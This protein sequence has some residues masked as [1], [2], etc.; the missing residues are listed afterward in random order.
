MTYDLIIRGG[1]LIDGTGG[2]AREGDV[3]VQGGRIVA[4]GEVEGDAAELIDAEGAIVTPGFIDLHTHYDGQA[5][6][7]T[8]MAPS[9]D[10][11]VTTIVM[12]NCGVGFAPVREADHDRLIR[13]MEGVEDIP[14]TALSEGISW[15]WES[16]PEYMTALD[17][18]RTMDVCAQVPHDALRVYVMG[19]RAIAGEVATEADIEA[20]ARLAREAMEA[21]ASGVS[22]GRTDTHR[23]ADGDPTPA[24]QASRRELVGLASALK[25]LGYGVLQAVSDFD[26][27]NGPERFDEEF[28]LLEAMALAAERPMSTTLLQRDMAPGQWESILK[29]AEALAAQGV[30]FKVQ[31]A[32][33]A[34][35][36]M[37]GLQATFHPFMGF[38]SYKAISHLPL[39]ERVARMRDPELKARMLTEQSEKVAGD[40]SAIPPMADMFLSKLEFLSTRIFKLGDPPQYEQPIERSLYYDAQAR[41]VGA[42]EA[43]YDALLEEEGEAL[44][45]FPLFNYGNFDLSDLYGMLNHPLA[46]SGLSDGGA[47]VG[48][49][50]DAS[51]PT[52]MLTHW[53]RDRTRGPR[54]PLERVVQMLTSANA[55]H[56]GLNDRGT[57]AVGQ[58]ADINVIDFDG[59]TL[60]RPQMVKDLPAG[61]QRLLQAAEGYRATIVSGQVVSRGGARTGALPGRLVRFG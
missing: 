48:T 34:I 3:A 12:G 37:L 42:L 28:D 49:V 23:T 51:F 21:G 20:M 47:H 29:R 38:P 33:R 55:A 17:V 10:H 13:L 15:A 32:A 26:M 24:A 60:R 5:S 22:T 9:C 1:R 56:L 6:W 11:G 16:F 25:G 46:L 35:G 57:L 18:P 7:D 61:G 43:L 8:E 27:G 40:G 50:C 59:L 4:L 39:A 36:V 58:K 54:L 19:D 14:G 44:L 41:G 2:P 52:F 45:Y 53:A 30:D 31:V